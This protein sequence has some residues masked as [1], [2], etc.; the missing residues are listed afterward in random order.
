MADL[1]KLIVFSF[2]RCWHLKKGPIITCRPG[3]PRSTVG[4]ITGTY[5]V[6]LGCGKEYAYD[7]ETGRVID[8]EPG[9]MKRIGLKFIELRGFTRKQ[10][11]GSEREVL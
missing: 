5:F 1:L 6:C 11:T 2:V 9:S 10:H 3:Q 8:P 4:S 7:L